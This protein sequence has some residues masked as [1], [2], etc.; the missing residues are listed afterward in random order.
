MSPYELLM[1]RLLHGEENCEMKNTCILR[2]PRLFAVSVPAITLTCNSA[3][4]DDLDATSS[5]LQSGFR[6]SKIF[7]VSLS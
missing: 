3:F 4:L 5:F 2:E 1:P 7:K 6:I